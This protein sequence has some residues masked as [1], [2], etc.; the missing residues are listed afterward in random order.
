[1]PDAH[2]DIDANAAH[3]PKASHIAPTMTGP[4]NVPMRETRLKYASF[5]VSPW[6]DCR[7]HV[8]PADIPRLDERPSHSCSNTSTVNK[9]DIGY[10]NG[11][12]VLATPTHPRTRR[13]PH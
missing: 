10:T 2:S 1:M 4:R 3:A 6:L 9:L 7:F 8:C 11:R 5:A 12:T 13:V